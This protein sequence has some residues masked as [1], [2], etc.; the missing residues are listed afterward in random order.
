MS[1]PHRDLHAVPELPEERAARGRDTS[2]WWA[3][4]AAV[5]FVLCAA[6]WYTAQQGAA[7]LQTELEATRAE[8]AGVNAELRAHQ[9]HLGA[10]RERSNALA[11]D[12]QALALEAQRVAEAVARD[13]RSPQ[14]RDGAEARPAGD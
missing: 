10:V 4:L 14:P 1:A 8:L 3:W 9:G 11:G 5:G 6:G 12:L 2:P 7:D 13:P